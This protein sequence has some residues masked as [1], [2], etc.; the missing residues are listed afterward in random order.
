MQICKEIAIHSRKA[1]P[2]SATQ[3]VGETRLEALETPAVG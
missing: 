1:A 2:G 3:G